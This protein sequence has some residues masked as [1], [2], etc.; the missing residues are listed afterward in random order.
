MG[1][2]RIALETG[3]LEDAQARIASLERR[4]YLEPDAEKLKAELT[5]RMQAQQ[6]GVVSL[7]E[8]R[9][10]LASNPDDLNLKFQLAESLAAAGQ[11]S[12]ALAL[13]LEL[14]ERDRKGKVGEQ[15]RQ[16]MLAI[17]QILPPDSELVIE[18]QRQLSFVLM[19]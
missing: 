16:T 6:S 7:E 17:F 1:L 14:G 2:A 11:Y 9:A 5:L 10:A 3:R 12:D 8:A 13:C 19:D 4:G 18:M 15:A